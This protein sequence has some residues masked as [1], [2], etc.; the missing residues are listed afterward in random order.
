MPAEAPLVEDRPRAV[1]LAAPAQPLR[2]L[3]AEDVAVNRELLRLFLE[4]KG[5][6]VD[7]V[8]DG[9]EA[10][11]AMS[12]KAYDLVIMDM[13]MPGMDGMD[14]TR[15]IRRL[16]GARAAAPIIALSANAMPDQVQGCLEAG[17]T[18]YLAKPFTSESLCAA[19]ERWSGRAGAAGNPIISLFVAQAGW[20]SV[21]GILEL[22]LSQIAA[23]EACPAQDPPELGRQAHALRGAASALG[24]EALSRACGALETACRIPGL[25]AGLLNTARAAAAACRA[26]VSA[27]LAQGAA[28]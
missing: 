11:E 6:L 26:E 13:Q 2:I 27:T 17:M 16:G 4:P 24:Y 10:V 19:V 25:D 8:C 9:F 7:T 15:A 12:R 5:Y 20:A 23:F 28:T 22:L 3:A 21:R 1:P 14:A 18:A